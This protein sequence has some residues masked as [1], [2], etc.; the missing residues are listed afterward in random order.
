MYLAKSDKKP[1]SGRRASNRK[2][3]VLPSGSPRAGTSSACAAERRQQR[4]C[5]AYLRGG[6]TEL[7]QMWRG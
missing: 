6:A 3:T 1:I 4:R 7:T 2:G 5:R